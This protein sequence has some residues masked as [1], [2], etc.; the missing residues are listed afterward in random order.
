MQPG[1]SMI[2]EY[3]KI[4]PNQ[5]VTESSGQILASGELTFLCDAFE[6]LG[7]ILDPIL[8]VV[9]ISGKLPDHL[10]SA[11]RS[12]ARHVARGEKD[13]FSNDKFML[14]R[15]LH[16]CQYRFSALQR[17]RP[18]RLLGSYNM[19]PRRLA[20]HNDTTKLPISQVSQ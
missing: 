19:P 20:S 18:V 3:G 10:V 2:R 6:S 4:G 11:A 14:Q 17:V 7:R 12:R 9:A 16:R 13:R 1:Y 5:Y 8:K 15:L